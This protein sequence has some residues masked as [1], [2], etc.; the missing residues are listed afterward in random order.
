MKVCRDSKRGAAAI[1]EKEKEEKLE[2][3]TKVRKVRRV[4]Y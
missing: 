2:R 3:A 1:R 4:R